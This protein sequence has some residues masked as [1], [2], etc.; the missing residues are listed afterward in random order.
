MSIFSKKPRIPK[1]QITYGKKSTLDNRF[2][3]NRTTNGNFRFS[4]T[5]SGFLQRFKKI[6]V[7]LFFIGALTFS[8]YGLFFSNYFKVKNIT[9]INEGF[10]NENLSKEIQE[11]LKGSINKSIF[12][13]DEEEIATKVLEQFPGLEKAN[14]NKNYPDTIEIDFSE[15]ALAANVINE[16]GNLK[17]SYLIN[18]MGF[19][20]KEDFENP[21]LLYIRIKSDEP[22]NT[23]NAVIEKSKLA[24]ILGAITHYE[25]KFGM[26]IKEVTYNPIARELHLLTERD[27]YIW[28]D[29]QRS[30][31]E[32]FKK[33]KKAIVKLDIF[34][35]N[36]Q[37]I[38]LRIAGGSG[39]KIIY[40][41]R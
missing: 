41:R 24:Y 40:K 27:F 36:L 1:Y 18:S 34:K 32:Q 12:W 4:R 3:R 37:Y 33:L 31:E 25:D 39:D 29:I 8:I 10:E 20:V 13:L 11:K 5:R 19:A 21:N 16:T 23:K 14:I 2:V 22:I 35:E 17:K 38:D 30:Y 7:L 6:S 26:K 9:I 28:L 15:Y